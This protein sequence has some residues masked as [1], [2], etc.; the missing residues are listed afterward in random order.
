MTVTTS[1]DESGTRLLQGGTGLLPR[2]NLLPPEIAER[3]AFRRIQGGLGV[4][5]VAVLLIMAFVVISASHSVSSAKQDLT[6]A[7]DEH[8]RLQNQAKAYAN[9]SAIY[10]AAD[11]AQAQLVTAMGTEV[12]FSQLLTDLSLNIPSSVWVS[13]VSMSTG[14]PTVTPA[15]TPSIGTFTVN[16]IGFSHNDV[17][18]WLESVAGLK[19]Y[20][21]PY[22][23]S[24]TEALLGT[25]KTVNF[26]STATLTP[27]ALSGR[28]TQQSGG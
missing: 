8:A 4:A 22:F 13:S 5:I 3:R 24:S 2:V 1:T 27:A 20:S 10:A 12:R 23:S 25:R 21:N 11:A 26:S 28:Y 6:A 14:L 7:Q 17:G 9:V 15:G 16:G 19:T 18:L